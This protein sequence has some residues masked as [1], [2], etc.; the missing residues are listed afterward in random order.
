MMTEPLA[1]NEEEPLSQLLIET[2]YMRAFG[3]AAALTAIEPLSGGTVNEIYRLDPA[4]G[5][6]VVLRIAPRQAA[7]TYWDDVALMRREYAVQPF[8]AAIG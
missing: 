8:F 4:D 1:P 5:L 3:S 7:D 2:L 6:S